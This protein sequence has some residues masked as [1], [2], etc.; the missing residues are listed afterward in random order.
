MI[1][2]VYLKTCLTLHDFC[3]AKH[4]PGYD[5]KRWV[6]TEDRVTEIGTLEIHPLTLLD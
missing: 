6:I 4:Q 2:T 5:M 3:H 1:K